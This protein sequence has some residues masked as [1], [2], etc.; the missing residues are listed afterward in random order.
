MQHSFI[1]IKE[2]SREPYSSILGY[3]KCSKRQLNSRILE[4]EK[5]KIK[6][7]SF[8]GPTTIGKLEILG[9]GYVGIVVLAKRRNNFV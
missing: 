1:S 2:F 6:S 3:P 9:K 7:I 5:L 4:L 8:T